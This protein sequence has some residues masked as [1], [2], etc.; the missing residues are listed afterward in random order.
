MENLLDEVV[1][2]LDGQN[3]RTKRVIPLPSCRAVKLGVFIDSDGRIKL[4]GQRHEDILGDIQSSTFEEIA[5][6]RK[7]I[8]NKK[9]A[10]PCATR[11]CFPYA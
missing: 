9:A 7:L 1:V 5:Q 4:C 10:G 2:F 8:L 11:E 6:A 3:L